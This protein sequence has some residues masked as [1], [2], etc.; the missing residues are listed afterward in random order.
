M[1]NENG[2]TDLGKDDQSLDVQP[3]QLRFVDAANSEGEIRNTVDK[4]MK[5]FTSYSD[6]RKSYESIWMEC[7]RMYVNAI[8]NLTTPTRARIFI[9]AV[10]QVIE[11]AVPKILTV[12][13]GGPTF[14][15]VVPDREEESGAAEIIQ[16]LLEYQLGQ[17]DFFLKFVDFIKQLL[18]YGTSYFKVY[19]KVR[20]QHVWSRVP[21]RGPQTILGFK[22][23]DNAITGWK[24]EKQYVVVERRPEI[25][26]LDI[27]DV[28]P[29]PIA[30]S[31]KDAKAI[32]IR[33]WLDIDE[34]REMGRGKFPVFDPVQSQRADLQGSNNTLNESRV[35]RKTARGVSGG[36][37]G[38]DKNQVEI[39][40]RWGLYD[41]DGDGI[42]E[43]CLF[44]I[45]N[46]TILLRAISNPFHHQ[47]KPIIRSVLFPVPLEWYGIGLVE[48]VIP[49]Q[50]ELNTLRRQR[51]DNINMAINRMWKVNSYADIDLETLVS[52]PNGIILTD[53]MDAIDTL[54]TADVTN[55]AYT[56]AAI[57][58]ND[59]ENATAPKSIQGS[60][61]SGKLGRT[62][63]GAELIIGQALE[64][65]GVAVK[66][67]E[68]SAVKKVLRMYY[69]LDLQFIDDDDVLQQTG[70]SM[71][72]HLFNQSVTPEDIRAE[73]SFKMKGI[74]E[75]VGSEGK[76]NQIVSFVS[77]FGKALSPVTIEAL[78]K[79]VWGLMDF[80]KNEIMIAAVQP[81]PP[82]NIVAS[83]PA[84]NQAV[85]NGAASPITGAPSGTGTGA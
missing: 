81:L 37:Q 6:A 31:E 83:G 60:P 73:V 4:L 29:D 34:V 48:P 39:L 74:S 58:Q 9:P 38:T 76:I 21:I 43:E 13:F 2:Q 85:N 54:P 11:A 66:L 67:I 26:V 78:A 70:K 77:V 61:E 27:L 84:T 35:F 44:V 5:E 28:Y 16:A 72:G 25:E 1:I 36:N 20:R 45:A 56:E 23:R 55:G 41:L 10:F 3:I 18:I 30:T 82:D 63:K 32:W 59:I 75:I 71:Y 46:R 24:E 53:D 8:E 64:K 17:S 7:Y 50:H 42:R 52:S 47:K 68:E 40:E 80:D 19:W 69:Q 33:S 12:I 49:L 62:A 51:L 57:V 14:F 15:E 79:K 22:I 65:F